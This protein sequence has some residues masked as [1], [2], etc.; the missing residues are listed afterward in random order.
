MADTSSRTL[1]LLSLLQGNRYWL[2]GELAERLGVSLRTLR[3]DVERLRDLGYPVSA[4]PGVGGGY[5][6]T[7][8]AT[9]PPLV[10]DDDEAVALTVGL[11]MATRS[12]LSGIAEAS[13]RALAKAIQVMPTRLRRRAQALDA[14]LATPASLTDPSPVETATLLA[15]GQACRDR[16]RVNFEYRDGQGRGSRRGVEPAQLVTV[17]RRWYL[18]CYDLDRGDWRTFRLDRISA[19]Q[20]TREH[21][22]PRAIPGGDANRFVERSRARS[23]VT[24]EFTADVA[25]P[26][27]QV[28]ERI[29]RWATVTDIDAARCR[30]EIPTN[31]A[32]WAAFALATCGRPLIRAHPVELRRV[33]ADWSTRLAPAGDPGTVPGGEPGTPPGGDTGARPAGEPGTS[34][35]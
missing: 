15:L 13:V 14:A 18:A 10:L 30:V 21:F 16:V 31:S 9:M 32:Q 23:P 8:G 27:D 33:L 19:V 4:E 2:G 12:D 35:D 34:P 25:G 28:R 5:Q 22:A 17:A 20:A 29:G 26:A 3:R 1:Q 24:E 7:R 6:M 11:N